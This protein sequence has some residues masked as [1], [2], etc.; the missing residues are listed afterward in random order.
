MATKKTATIE[1]GKIVRLKA[2]GYSFD[3]RDNEQWRK[4]ERS[5]TVRDFLDQERGDL[6]WLQRFIAAGNVAIEPIVARSSSAILPRLPMGAPTEATRLAY[7][8]QLKSFIETI[9]EVNSTLDFKVSS[10]GWCYILEEHGLVKGD[11]GKAQKLINDLRKDGSLPVDICAPDETRATDNVQDID[12]TVAEEASQAIYNV[13]HYHETYT[14]FSFWRDQ[15]YYIEML[16]E[17]GDL[18]SLFADECERY[19]IPISNAKGWGD[20]NGRYAMMQR[21]CAPST[22]MPTFNISYARV[23]IMKS[24]TK[25]T[26]TD[27]ASHIFVSGV[28]F[29]ELQKLGV[30]PRTDNYNLDEVRKAYIEH[31]RNVAS[32]RGSQA[33]L[34]LASERA[35][36]AEAQRQGQ[37]MKNMERAGELIPCDRIIPLVESQYSVI[38]ERLLSIPGKTANSLVGKSRSEITTLLETEINQSLAELSAVEVEDQARKPGSDD[39]E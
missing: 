14:P 8:R 34:D 38:R 20:I 15:E 18:K 19:H 22:N 27:A 21:L 39:E 33:N 31:I 29:R 24:K 13:K 11:F 36:L 35:K 10:R 12:G 30:L 25:T 2:P 3:R 26:Q 6:K 4:V 28:R 16:V 9:E 17:K 5:E 37:N 32:G 23:P 7:G 1:D